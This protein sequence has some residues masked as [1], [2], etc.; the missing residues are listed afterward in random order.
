VDVEICVSKN[1]VWLDV[2]SAEPNFQGSMECMESSILLQGSYGPANFADEDSAAASVS[3][4]LHGPLF[5]V[6]RFN[7]TSMLYL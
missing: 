4:A 3:G 5:Q 2:V 7:P 6:A 1:Q